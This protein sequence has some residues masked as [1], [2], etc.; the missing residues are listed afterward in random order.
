MNHGT[1]PEE[2]LL[3]A[4]QGEQAA[5]EQ[6]A[7]RYTPML[8]SIARSYQLSEAD[9]SDV[10]QTTWL[11]LLEHLTELT[12]GSALAGWLATTARREALRT[13]RLS[14]R[15]STA[16]I[17]E[18]DDHADP[19]TSSP[20][21]V[22]L[23]DERMHALTRA[24]DQLPPQCRQ[25]LT[26][27][28]SEP[29]ATYADIAAALGMPVGSIGPTR[30]RCLARLRRL[31]AL[32]EVAGVPASP[33]HTSATTD[34]QPA[35]TGKTLSQPQDEDVLELMRGVT[36]RIVPSAVI[37]ESRRNL[38]RTHAGTTTAALVSDSALEPHGLDKRTDE[39]VRKLR[40]WSA[41]YEIYLEIRAIGEE[42]NIEGELK[43]PQNAHI[44]LRWKGGARE[45]AATQTTAGFSA[46]GVPVGLVSLHIQT[47]DGGQLTTDWVAI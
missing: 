43:P 19:E 41:K 24:L 13:A 6:L 16:A 30:A 45:L 35:T 40:F 17:E 37:D 1:N 20:E 29:P 7:W 11:R 36:T 3:A 15:I 22:I 42:R 31:F 47:S 39:A 26:L 21:N 46:H 33:H 18:L 5:F 28:I 23:S 34:P 9:A 12:S 8:W 27:L 25:L 38:S 10:V 14:T 32:A 44:W 2:T 4:Q